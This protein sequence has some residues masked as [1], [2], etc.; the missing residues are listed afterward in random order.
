MVGALMQL[1]AYG[2]QDIY[3]RPRY[4]KFFRV[5]SADKFKYHGY[6]TPDYDN[7]FN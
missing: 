5:R 7:V 4:E 1:I 2:A 3:L 6:L